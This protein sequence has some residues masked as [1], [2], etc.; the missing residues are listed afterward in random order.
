[1]SAKTPPYNTQTVRKWVSFQRRYSLLTQTI[2][3][4][5]V[6]FGR[7]CAVT[8]AVSNVGYFYGL[9]IPEGRRIHIWRRDLEVTQGVY[10]VDL[11]SAPSGFT[12]GNKAY[13]KVLYQGGA[14]TVGTD[15]WCGVTPVNTEELATVFQFPLIDTGTAIGAGRVEGAAAKDGTLKSF[16]DGS[17]LIRVRR[18][19]AGAFT[20]SIGLIAW[21]EDDV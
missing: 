13:R 2:N 4:G 16:R 11:V 20:S 10:E 18:T 1:M 21:E 12:G 9:A 15:V 14:A 8:S 6:E 17:V 5:A 3:N 7:R 19:T